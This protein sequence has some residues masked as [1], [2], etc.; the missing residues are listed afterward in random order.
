MVLLLGL[1]LLL[2]L[3]PP[4]AVL[5]LLV[6]CVSVLLLLAPAWLLLL[7]LLLCW[8]AE[9]AATSCCCGWSRS[10]QSSCCAAG[11]TD[12]HQGNKHA[13]SGLS[14]CVRVRSVAY[15]D[16]YHACLCNHVQPFQQALRQLPRDRTKQ[17]QILAHAPHV[18][19]L[20][21]L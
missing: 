20:A 11:S 2:P 7:I 6:G 9:Q 8:P 5:M 1:L 18:Q 16:W 4:A 3:A 10:V 21:W 17:C 13:K 15:C 14:L 19:L 12:L